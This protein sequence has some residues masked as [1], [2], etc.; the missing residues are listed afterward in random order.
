MSMYL[1]PRRG[2][3]NYSLALGGSRL[4]TL[5]LSSCCYLPTRAGP[6]GVNPRES[7]PRREHST[8][9]WLKGQSGGIEV[10]HRGAFPPNPAR[11]PKG[12]A[13]SSF[14]AA[15]KEAS[16]GPSGGIGSLCPRSRSIPPNGL[17]TPCERLP[18]LPEGQPICQGF[19]C[20]CGGRRRPTRT[21]RLCRLR[22]CCT[23]TSGEL[24]LNLG[25]LAVWARYQG[26][27]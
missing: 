23:R 17:R 3:R 1:S 21:S 5:A 6:Q 19:P 26:V 15:R 22:C 25:K 20:T 7:T 4:L 14:P 8:C 24:C 18:D 13:P 2:R 9:C 12:W 27:D 10:G 16:E 11:P